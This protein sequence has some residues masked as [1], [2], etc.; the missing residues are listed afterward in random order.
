MQEKPVNLASTKVDSATSPDTQ[1]GDTAP[2]DPA[3]RPGRG[4][5]Q[6]VGNYRAIVEARAIYYPVAYRFVRELGR[7]RQ[8]IV[9][10]GLRQG[11]RGSVTRHAIKIFDPGIYPSAKKYWTDMGRIAAQ[12]TRLQTVKSPNL[13]TPDIYEE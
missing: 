12:T 10:L 9:Y 2:M 3:F 13:V 8:G 7:G 11:A 1:R 5:A 4:T 6:L